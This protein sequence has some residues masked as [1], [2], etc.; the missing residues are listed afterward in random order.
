MIVEDAESSG[1]LW[2]VHE[3]PIALHHEEVFGC[4]T[5]AGGLCRW[6]AVDAQVEARAGGLIVLA[7]DRGWKSTTTIAILEIDPGGRV[8]WDWQA[9]SSDRHAPLYWEVEP[10]VEQGCVV[11]LRQGPFPAA[12]AEALRLMA[13]EAQYWTWHLCNLRGVLEAK[14]DM[15]AVRPL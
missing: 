4:F 11:R 2:I 10:S 5:T 15:R 8:T 1:Q 6:L 12:D 3:Q 7:W 13:E 9:A 14:H